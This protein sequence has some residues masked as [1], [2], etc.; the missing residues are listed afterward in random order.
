[1][2]APDAD[3]P[4]AAPGAL[5]RAT[6]A[7]RHRNYRLFFLGQLVSLVG[8]WMQIVA[9]GWLVFRLTDSALALGVAGFAT[10]FPMFAFGPFMGSVA[11]RLPRR[12][13]LVATSLASCVLAL[14]MGLLTVTHRID[15]VTLLVLAFLLGTV[16]ALD[17]PTRQSFTIE[18]VGRD[19]LPNAIALNASMFNAARMIG[20]AIGGIVVG[21]VGEGW[22]FLGNG[23]SYLAATLALLAMRIAPAAP[24]PARGGRLSEL[25][26]GIRHAASNPG[27][28]RPLLLLGIVSL[29]GM[30]YAT[31]MPIFVNDILGGGPKGL[32]LLMSASGLGAL[33]GALTLTTRNGPVENLAAWPAR[34]AAAFGAG[35]ICFALST[36]FWLS[37]ALLAASGLA[38]MVQAGTTNML[39]QHRVPDSLRG[40][41][42][43]LY[44]TTFLGLAPFGAL[45]AGAAAHR[46]G[47]PATVVLCGAASLAAALCFGLAGLGRR[48]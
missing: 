35:L 24:A 34:A 22:C 3:P 9:Q 31:L 41:I 16:N 23:V 25:V 48:R 42:M 15:L 1:M 27:I 43:A 28:G 29:A 5:A 19:D 44:T 11:D 18:L 37:A 26:G 32:G 20:P 8:T 14:A 12:R 21:L 47:A 38:L 2:D 33:A 6:R 36:S 45:I 39:I 4:E 40:R 17:A 46:I 7:F 10:A 30:P 13:I